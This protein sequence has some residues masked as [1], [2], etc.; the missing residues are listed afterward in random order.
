MDNVIKFEVVY[1]NPC[2]PIAKNSLKCSFTLY[3]QSIKMDKIDKNIQE[4]LFSD[5][6][7]KVISALDSIKAK[8][9]K[10]YIPILFDLLN[11]KPEIEVENEIKKLLA[12]VKDKET[13][14]TFVDALKD[15]KYKPILK[16]ILTA[17]WQNGLDFS[18]YLLE[19]IDIIIKEDWEIA[20]EAFTIIDNFEFI[21]PHHIID[22][23]RPKLE[24]AIAEADDQKVYFLEEVLKMIN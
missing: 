21:P 8:G 16:S 2:K 6:T 3:L 19:F 15:K 13:V 4:N 17:C 10:L 24:A 1:E 23:A 22:E 14:E 11:S 7:K 12:T 20:F 9:N 5:N 18:D